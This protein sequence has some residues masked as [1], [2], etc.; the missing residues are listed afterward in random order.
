MS[1]GY[2]NDDNEWH[3]CL[4]EAAETDMP[5]KLRSLFATILTNCEPKDPLDLWNRHHTNFY[6]FDPHSG[7]SVPELIFRAYYQIEKIIQK[8]NGSYTLADTYKI[9]VPSGNFPLTHHDLHQENRE[10][11]AQLAAE[12]HS[13]L[14]NVQ[15]AAFDAIL[16]SVHNQSGK[17]FFIDG[18]G[19]TG[20]SYTYKALISTLIGENRKVCTVASTGIAA[21]LIGGVTAHKRFGIPIKLD[22]DSVSN[23]SNQSKEAQLLRE[24]DLIIWDEA[25]ASHKHALQLVDSL[26]P[27]YHGQPASL[28]WQDSCVRG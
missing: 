8:Q 11:H 12:M 13:S 24:S 1:R 15:L 9:P 2:L 17:Q 4:E 21:T 3:H 22:H 26:A 7:I 23:I 6:R 20:K 27:R 16:D 18:P 28:W 25:T 10:E 5:H 14:N 19:G